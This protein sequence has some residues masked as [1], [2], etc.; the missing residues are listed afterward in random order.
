MI[1]EQPTAECLEMSNDPIMT[2]RT[3]LPVMEISIENEMEASQ[4][5]KI[6]MSPN[7]REMKCWTIALGQNDSPTLKSF[8][9]LAAP[10]LNSTLL[11][12]V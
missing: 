7:I 3:E 8:S 1:E 4:K 10:G 11:T 5:T 6:E 9:S 2:R 12:P